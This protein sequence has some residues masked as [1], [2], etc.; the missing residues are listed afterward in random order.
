MQKLLLK[1]LKS[2][3]KLYYYIVLFFNI[4]FLNI[5]SIIF[6]YYYKLPAN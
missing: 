4:T 1:L 2:N 3:K 5:K 6:S